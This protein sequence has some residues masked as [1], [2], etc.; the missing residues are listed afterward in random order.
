M[1]ELISIEHG[2]MGWDGMGW[3][4]GSRGSLA[5]CSIVQPTTQILGGGGGEAR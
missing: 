5:A 3:D 2:W 4:G 1:N